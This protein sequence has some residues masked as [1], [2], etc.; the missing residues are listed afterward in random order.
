MRVGNTPAQRDA[1]N[2]TG[3]ATSS[4]W[5]LNNV[6]GINTVYAAFSGG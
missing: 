4:G 5:T 3:F 1:G 6:D 2:R